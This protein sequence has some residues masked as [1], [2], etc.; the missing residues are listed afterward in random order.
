VTII[1]ISNVGV[2]VGMVGRGVTDGVGILVGNREEVSVAGIVV[3]GC[4]IA[5]GLEHAVL[6]KT[7]AIQI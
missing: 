6:S 4:V 2:N 1:E 7:T 5:T 3:T